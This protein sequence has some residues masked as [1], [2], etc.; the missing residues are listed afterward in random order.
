M[1]GDAGR[2]RQVFVNIL[3]NSVKYTP[4]G[5]LLE[6]EVHEKDSR[7]H[8]YSCY[9]FIFRDNG[10]GMDEEFVRRIFEPFSRAED[11]RISSIEGTGLGMTI[12]QNI[13]RIMGGSIAVK[14]QPGEGSQFTVTIFL[15]QQDGAV[16]LQE[17]ETLEVSL[18]GRRLL[19]AE[20]NEIN[21]EIACEILA[22]AGASVDCAE[23]GRQALERFTEAAPGYYDMILMDIQ[24]PVMNGYEAARAIR[25]LPRPD[26]AAIPIIAMSANAFAEDIGESRAAGMNAHVT[27]PLDIP[28]LLQCL[29]HWLSRQPPEQG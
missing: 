10:V 25:S 4:P 8:G 28:K 9:D 16:P 23:N 17:E 21:R 18:Q 11:S 26:G 12:A 14:S 29:D 24:M 3:G 22:E 27:K 13:V 20:D 15:R 7:Q 2:L 1:L 19:L 6:I 5:G